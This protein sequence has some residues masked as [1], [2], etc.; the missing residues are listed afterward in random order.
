M[1][2][3]SAGIGAGLGDFCEARRARPS[4]SQVVVMVVDTSDLW[5]IPAVLLD[6]SR[7]PQVTSPSAGIGA[8]SLVT[9]SEGW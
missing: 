9:T 5:P 4:S 2:S 6:T 7:I 8:G 3:P 1:T